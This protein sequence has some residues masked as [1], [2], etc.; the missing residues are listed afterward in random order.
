MIKCKFS[1][2][3]NELQL[4]LA[5]SVVS[6]YWAV[7]KIALYILLHWLCFLLTFTFTFNVFKWGQNSRLLER[8]D[9]KKRL[10]FRRAFFT[11]N[12]FSKWRVKNIKDTN[13]IGHN[14]YSLVVVFSYFNFLHCTDFSSSYCCGDA[15]FPS[16][17]LMKVFF[18]S[19]HM[20]ATMPPHH[21]S[22]LLT[23]HD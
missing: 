18:F 4:F 11:T 8:Y 13:F 20:W 7:G 12:F 15:N 14:L 9:A 17:G 10:V 3:Q 5:W 1:W 19:L 2:M 21:S 23:I 22:R 16:V 6:A